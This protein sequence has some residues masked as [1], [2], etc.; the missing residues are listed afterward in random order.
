VKIMG[1]SVRMSAVTPDIL[2]ELPFCGFTQSLQANSV[3]VSR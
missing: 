3:I 2:T 1:G